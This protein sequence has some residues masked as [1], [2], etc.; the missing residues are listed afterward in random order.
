M[1]IQVQPRLNANKDKWLKLAKDNNF[2]F[3][4]EELA[5]PVSDDRKKELVEYY[6]STGLVNSFHGAF[7]DNNPA[8]NDPLI[9]QVSMDRC[10]ESCKLAV[11]LGAKNIVFHSSCYP[12]LRG[13]YL[14]TWVKRSADFYCDLAR[15]YK[16]NIFIENSFD[17]DPLPL[18]RL[19]RQCEVPYVRACLD[20]GHVNYSREPIEVWIDSLAE[21]IGYVHLSDNMGQFDDH[22]TLGKGITPWDIVD[23]ILPQLGYKINVTL[24]TGDY[25]CTENS[26]NYLKRNK[27]ILGYNKPF[28][29]EFN[30]DYFD[31]AKNPQIMEFGLSRK[32]KKAIEIKKN[33]NRE[34]QF[35]RRNRVMQKIFSKYLSNEIVH[36]ALEHPES[37]E[38]GGKKRRLTMLMSDLHGFTQMSE[39][40][41]AEDLL[42]VL[43]NYFSVMLEIIHRYHGTVIDIIGDGML[44]AFGLFDD[45]DS[46]ADKAIGAAIEMQIYMKEVNRWNKEH[47]FPNLY[48]GIGINTGTVVV[49]NIG[50]SRH[51]KYGV[52]GKNVNLCSRI[53]S[54][55]YNGQILISNKTKEECESELVIDSEE[56]VYPKG[57]SKPVTLYHVVRI[58]GLYNKEYR[59]EKLEYKVLK[60]KLEIDFSFIHSK[61]QTA[62]MHQ[63]YIISA[64]ETGAII[65]TN[66]PIEKNDNI[67]IDITE[68]LFCK[69]INESD[70]SNRWELSFTALPTIFEEWLHKILK[71]A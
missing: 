56:T 25:I 41:T 5:F 40:L 60:Q 13:T 12:F 32:E 66:E 34:K 6:K 50:S 11:E 43:N 37:L 58:N 23:E 61:H 68:P 27:Y 20:F 7:I 42:T 36:R 31:T 44:V 29:C 69:V 4:I 28:E 1:N 21:Y 46:H 18:H 48:M 19:M 52:V 17:V 70:G 45:T 10:N 62:E 38:L 54:Y 57:S 53:E 33:H 8:S 55:T 16:L 22:L 71:N 47:K 14:D 35:A 24:E 26:V 65:E 49:G 59:P 63:G 2:K 51:I 9:A 67:A 64:S 15:K 30:E 3:E 39:K